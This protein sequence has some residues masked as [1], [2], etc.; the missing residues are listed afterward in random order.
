MPPEGPDRPRRAWPENTKAHAATQGRV[1]RF[2]NFTKEGRFST[3]LFE[4][5][6]RSEGALVATLAEMYVQGVSTKK[7]KVITEAVEIT[8]SERHGHDREDLAAETYMW[9]LQRILWRDG[10]GRMHTSTLRRCRA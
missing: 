4:R 3:E 6:Q 10:P 1:P 2:C 5:Y 8:N 7:V 9:R